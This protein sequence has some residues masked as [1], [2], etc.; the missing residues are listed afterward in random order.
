MGHYQ[1]KKAFYGLSDIPTVFQKH[2][3]TV[4][5]LKHQYHIICVT[6]GSIDYNEREVREVFTKLQNADY[7]ASEEKTE[8]FKRELTWLGYYIN[9]EAVKPIGEKTEAITELE[10]PNNVK[11][12]KYFLGSSQHLSNFINNLSLKTEKLRKLLKKDVSWEW[13]PE[14]DEG[15]KKLKKR[16]WKPCV[17]PNS[18]QGETFTSRLTHAT[19]EQHCGKRKVKYSE[20]LLLQVK[21]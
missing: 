15:F 14:I 4:L 18:T 11:E 7:R 10:A 21:F 13:T 19:P 2:I 9:Q 20:L 12:L 3:H 8:V 5:E 17:W 1:F 16:S 6:N